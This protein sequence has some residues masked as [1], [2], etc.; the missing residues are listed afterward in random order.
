MEELTGDRFTLPYN[1][2]ISIKVQA[3]NLRGWSELS[4]ANVIG[5]YAEVVPV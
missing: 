4:T 3:Y 1:R 5:A 2:F